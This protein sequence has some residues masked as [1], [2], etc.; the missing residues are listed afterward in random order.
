MK[1]TYTHIALLVATLIPILLVM[2]L[3]YM[4]GM[5]TLEDKPRS[6]TRRSGRIDVQP[7]CADLLTI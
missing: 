3:L 6:F 4:L 2:S 7:V 5:A 1:R